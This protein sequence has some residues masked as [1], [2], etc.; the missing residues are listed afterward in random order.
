MGLIGRILDRSSLSRPVDSE[1]NERKNSALR[2]HNKKELQ[3]L[4]VVVVD[5]AIDFVRSP[6]IVH[7]LESPFCCLRF[8]PMKTGFYN[9]LV[10]SFKVRYMQAI[11]EAARKIRAK[12]RKVEQERGPR[13]WKYRSEEISTSVDLTTWKWVA[14]EKKHGQEFQSLL[15]M[16][17]R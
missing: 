1:K 13:E 9:W 4:S 6:C 15:E 11:S 10:N 17:A 7:C 8:A 5:I 3:K 14:A 12:R 2:W 16:D